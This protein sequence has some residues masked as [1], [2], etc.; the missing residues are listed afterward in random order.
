[1][2]EQPGSRAV[3][4]GLAEQERPETDVCHWDENM[5]TFQRKGKGRERYLIKSVCFFEQMGKKKKDVAFKKTW[6]V[7]FRGEKK[8]ELKMRILWEKF[9]FVTR[10]EVWA[11][12]V[13]SIKC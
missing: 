1:M 7:T 3:W 12:M 13:S 8:L 4:W 6:I 9:L 10:K 11:Q 2:E 5:Q